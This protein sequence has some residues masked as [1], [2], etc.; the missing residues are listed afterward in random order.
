MSDD[1]LPAVRRDPELDRFARFGMWLAATES[2]GT[3]ANSRGMAAA[4]RFAYVDA[5]ELPPMAASELSVINGKVFIG[6]KLR[7]AL[8]RRAGYRVVRVELTPDMCTAALVDVE[9][10]EELGRATYTIDDAKRAGLAG[11]SSWKTYPERMLWARASSYVLDDFAPETTLGM[12]AIEDKDEI[13]G[14][15]AKTK[16]EVFVAE[17][18]EEFADEVEWPDHLEDAQVAADAQRDAAK[19]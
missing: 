5:L 14:T 10:G 2:G 13:L 15:T 11:K 8:A 19:G 12:Y 1:N 7:R 4:L 3:D 9:T 6:A 17:F 18:E 16:E